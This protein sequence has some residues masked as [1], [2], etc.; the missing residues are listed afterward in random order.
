VVVAFACGSF[1]LFPGYSVLSFSI[2]VNLDGSWVDSC[3]F[4]SG[5]GEHGRSLSPR[6]RLTG[7]F[8]WAM[9]YKT[10]GLEC[11]HLLMMPIDETE[12]RLI[13]DIQPGPI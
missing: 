6:E 13:V 12:L 5:V 4:P 3:L 8:R 9:P 10:G 1:V 7:M 11:E 2:L